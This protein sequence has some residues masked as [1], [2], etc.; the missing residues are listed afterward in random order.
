MKRIEEITET[1]LVLFISDEGKRD[2]GTEQDCL[3]YAFRYQDGDCFA[4]S[5]QIRPNYGQSFN[6]GNRTKTPN[7]IQG[8]NN[9]VNAGMHNSVLGRGNSVTRNGS[10][11]IVKGRNGYA[12][13]FGENVYSV[14]DIENR[15][16]YVEV[17][18]IGSTTDDNPTALFIGGRGNQRFIPNP[19]YATCYFINWYATALNAESG[20][21]WTQQNFTAF[22]NILGNF[23]DVGNHSPVTLRDSNLDY[24]VDISPDKQ[25][26]DYI[27]VY[28]EGEANHNVVWNVVLQ[29]TEV[30][31]EEIIGSELVQNGSF[32]ELGP[33]II[34]NNDFSNGLTG[35]N[36]A[37]GVTES[38]GVVTIPN[39]KWLADLSVS[40]DDDKYY[41][42]QVDGSGGDIRMRIGF[43][44][45]YSYVVRP[46]PTSWSEKLRVTLLDFSYSIH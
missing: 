33:E 17:H 42:F 45:G 36:K 20:E 46:L 2:S 41:Y 12:E 29:I 4:Y 28:V 8:I 37:S 44:G 7:S 24:S 34:T 31:I 38:G 13:N 14:S 18:Y 5:Q 27:S 15:A 40:Y 22:K 11:V 9:N 6:T 3:E 35:W 39:T 32:E 30:R 25:G 43:S 16:R 23:Q 1:G 10:N 26:G 21:I 19:N